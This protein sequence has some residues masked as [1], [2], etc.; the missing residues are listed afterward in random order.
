MAGTTI[1]EAETTA[2]HY[3]WPRTSSTPLTIHIAQLSAVTGIG[4]IAIVRID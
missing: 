4:R 1:H 3:D 2:P